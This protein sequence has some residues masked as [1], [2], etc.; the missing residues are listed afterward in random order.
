MALCL[1]ECVKSL[2][3]KEKIQSQTTWGTEDCYIYNLIS[4][5]PIQTK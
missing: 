2:G 4:E 3:E 5:I 1:K